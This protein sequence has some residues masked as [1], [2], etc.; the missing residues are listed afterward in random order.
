ML[1]NDYH[2]GPGCLQR[3][4]MNKISQYLNIPLFI[5]IYYIVFHKACLPLI[6]P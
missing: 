2:G 1:Y 5:I 6:F 4:L 3:K